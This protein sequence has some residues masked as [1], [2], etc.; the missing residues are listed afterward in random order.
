MVDLLIETDV[1]GMDAA[2]VNV[3]PREHGAEPAF[4]RAA[5]HVVIEL[6]DA[7]AFAVGIP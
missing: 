7:A 2:A 5:A 1:R 6:R 4:E 3:P